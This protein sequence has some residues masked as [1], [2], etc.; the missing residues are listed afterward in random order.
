MYMS[1]RMTKP[2]KWPSEDSDQPGLWLSLERTVKTLIRL[3]EAQVD[4]SFRWA[5][6]LFCLF[7]HAAANMFYEFLRYSMFVQKL[8]SIHNFQG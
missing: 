7:C 4:L 5:H 8:L 1:L 3:G 6:M 2:T